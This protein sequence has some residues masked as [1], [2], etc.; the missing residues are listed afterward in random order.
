MK[1]E[2]SFK[3]ILALV[4]SLFTTSLIVWWWIWALKLSNQVSEQNHRMIKY[5]GIALIGFVVLGGIFLVSYV[6]QDHKRNQ[7]IQLFFST[8]SHDIKTSISRL[9]LQAE[10][11]EEELPQAK[12]PSLS[13]FIQD[14]VQLDLQLENSLL[15]TNI[16]EY[17]FLMEKVKL[18][19]LIGTIR[20][21]FT[22]LNIELKQDAELTT[23]KKWFLSILKNIFQNSLL[24]GKANHIEISVKP[25]AHESIAISIKD[26]G[27]GYSSGNVSQ[28]GSDIF[29]SNHSQSNGIGLYL[30]KSL[31]S[32]MNGALSFRSTP[33]G[34]TS[35]INVRGKI[36]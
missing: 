3:L 24:H 12:H 32:K 31:L 10:I 18:S 5:E 28:L 17:Q 4:W 9:R 15:F 22:N 19:Q 7:K 30:S 26:N 6:W 35:H 20:S 8:F 29:K 2:I 14:V 16:N 27:V 23:D 34:F 13:R 36:L 33:Q 11:M 21:D 1:T 25:D